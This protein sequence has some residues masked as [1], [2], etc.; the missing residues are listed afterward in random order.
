M[1]NS[2]FVNVRGQNLLANSLWSGG[3]EFLIIAIPGDR[4]D[5]ATADI[6]AQQQEIKIEPGMRIKDKRSGIEFKILSKPTGY[7]KQ[8]EIEDEIHQNFRFAG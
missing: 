3:Q 6:Y 7:Y 8:V 1:N 2:E 4:Q 5:S